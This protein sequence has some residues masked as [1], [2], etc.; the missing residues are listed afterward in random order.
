MSERMTEAELT[1]IETFEAI[2]SQTNRPN[3]H[4]RGLLVEVRRLRG[5]IVGAI[6]ERQE[7]GCQDCVTR[8]GDRWDAFQAEAEAIQA[9]SVARP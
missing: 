9:E 1:E 7:C 8:H 4:I 3:M 2:R 6:P 5:L